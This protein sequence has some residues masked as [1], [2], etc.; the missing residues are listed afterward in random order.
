[1][2]PTH[3]T[4]AP[5][6]RHI[7]NLIRSAG[8]AL[9]GRERARDR[10]VR[11]NS[12]DVDDGR[13]QPWSPIG[14]GSIGHGL[15][16]REALV[17][18]AEELRRQLWKELPVREIRAARQRR[19]EAAAE[20][21]GYQDGAAAPVGRP[22]T[23]RQ[24]IERLDVVLARGHNR[25]QRLDVT[26]LQATLKF[27]DFATGRLFPCIE[28][29]A[30][31]AGCHRNSVVNALRRLSAHGILSWVRR[32]QKTGNDGEFGPQREQTSNAYYF[33]HR[34]RMA[35]RVWQRFCQLLTMKVRR[36]GARIAAPAA[37]KPG[38]LPEVK[39]PALRKALDRLGAL[40]PNAST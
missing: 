19:D 25:L 38:A 21:R 29:I 20:L 32:S 28:T 16:H 22:A 6:S 23:L 9:S 3:E 31:S 15:A 12:F 1:M 24:E 36:L 7:R 2:S 8:A 35:P 33:E 5:A 13:A 27:V 14:D 4:G 37:A 17:R 11:R 39:D 30:E 40:I 10:E 26:V 18:T 34:Q